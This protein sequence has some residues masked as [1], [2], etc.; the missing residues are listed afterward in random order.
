MVV[1]AN[2]K[3]ESNNEGI[4]NSFDTIL[5]C[6][7]LAKTPT[8][9]GSFVTTVEAVYST[10]TAESLHSDSP[11]LMLTGIGAPGSSGNR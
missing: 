7:S 8:I 4:N 6:N 10:S 5:R 9:V 2:A 11:Y 3:R 1:S